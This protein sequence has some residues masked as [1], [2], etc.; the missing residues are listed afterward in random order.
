MLPLAS[1]VESM[2]FWEGFV[3]V[4]GGLLCGMAVG[5]RLLGPRA[6]ACAA[7]I[8]VIAF[9]GGGFSGHYGIGGTTWLHFV[10]NTL[11][12]LLVAGLALWLFAA[13]VRKGK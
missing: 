2:L 5:R 4:L 3:W 13:L 8:G 1:T 6:A 10:I 9:V 7:C 12:G 11:I